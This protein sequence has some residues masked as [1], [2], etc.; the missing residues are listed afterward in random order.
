MGIHRDTMKQEMTLR[1]FSP[2]TQKAY[3]SWMRRLVMHSRVPADQISERQLRSF[4]VYL[5]EGKLSSATINQAISACGFFF[6]HVLPREWKLDIQYQRTPQHLPVTLS[7]EEVRRLLDA[8]GSLRERAAME[9]AYSAGLRLG[10]VLHL[11]VSDI[12]SSRM[13]I[14]IEQGKGKKDRNVMLADS[15]LETLRAYWKQE[16]PRGWL[17]PGQDDQQPLNATIFQRAFVVAKQAAR[18]EKRVSFHSLRHSFATHLMES[19]VS[20]RTIQALLG[21]RSLNTTQRYTHVAGDY[22]R[23][24]R[25][26]LDRLREMPPR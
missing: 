17:F 3:L 8:T 4:V 22:L 26:P 16:R 6:R 25:S 7:V 5:S 10:E 11:K 12:D 19:G 24:T 13:I 20:V 9:L 23:E 1:G 15:L 21:H 18:I 14:R 2:R